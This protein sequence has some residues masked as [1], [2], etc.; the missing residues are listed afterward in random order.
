MY[1]DPAQILLLADQLT[2]WVVFHRR[3]KVILGEAIR[4]RPI[5]QPARYC[6]VLPNATNNE[7]HGEPHFFGK[8][9]IICDIYL[10]PILHSLNKS[11]MTI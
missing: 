7:K 1:P 2:G 4:P 9:F 10:P 11:A 3:L 5:P 8:G 6:L